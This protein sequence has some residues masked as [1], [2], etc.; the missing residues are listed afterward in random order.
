MASTYSNGASSSV[1]NWDHFANNLDQ[2]VPSERYE[3]ASKTPEFMVRLDDIASSTVEGYEDYV[4][5]FHFAYEINRFTNPNVADQLY[6]SGRVSIEDPL[7][8][9][10]N[11][12]FSPVL[13]MK[14]MRGDLIEEVHV[15][16]LAN[17][18]ETNVCV[19]EIIFTD[20][21]LQR[22]LPKYDTVIFTFRPETFENIVYTYDQKGQ[23]QGTTSV[24]FDLRTGQ[25]V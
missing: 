11:G 9:L 23:L 7:M 21:Y 17:I 8:V 6:T 24:K 14:L 25:L 13:Q 1:S 20:V 2:I 5:L 22:C 18:F 19:Q 16:R 12:Y 15:K 4:Q 10:P 3:N